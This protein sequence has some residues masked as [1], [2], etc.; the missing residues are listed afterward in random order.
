MNQKSFAPKIIHETVPTTSVTMLDHLHSWFAEWLFNP[1]LGHFLWEDLL[2]HYATTK[3]LGL[4]E[5]PIVMSTN[6]IVYKSNYAKFMNFSCGVSDRPFVEL[7]NYTQ[8][9]QTRYV[10]FRKLQAGGSMPVFQREHM[11]Y[12]IGKEPIFE[13]FRT[14]ILKCHGLDPDH[15]PKSHRIVITK[16][17]KGQFQRSIYNLNELVDFLELTY[18]DIPIQVVDWSSM[19]IEEQLQLL[20]N[21]TI[22]VTP[23]GGVSMTAPFL[24]RGAH[25]IFMDYYVSH[26]MYG[27]REGESGS[28]E[29]AFWGHWPYLKKSYYQVR[30]SSDYRMDAKG[31]QDT[32]WYAS[33]VVNMERIRELIDSSL[34]DMEL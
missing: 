5:E 33:V 14:R 23:A 11:S 4:D 16:K 32:R 25:A 34:E 15:V 24:P 22:L 30:N 1:N 12:N 21:T 10:C 26:T 29:A 20:L 6:G 13:S 27:F 2:G 31:Y 3:R 7:V 28:M 8:T 9:F 17:K 18:P 19:S